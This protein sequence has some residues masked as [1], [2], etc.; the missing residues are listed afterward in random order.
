MTTK[1]EG[2]ETIGNQAPNVIDTF[3]IADFLPSVLAETM[4]ILNALYPNTSL[5]C[6]ANILL[7]KMGQVV[8]CKRIMFKELVNVKLINHYAINLM[9]SGLGKDRICDDIDKHFLKIFIIYF[10]D[11]ARDY[12]LNQENKINQDAIEKFKVEKDRKQYIKEEMAAIRAIEIEV[13]KA[14]PEG[15]FQDAKTLE[16]ADFGSIF[17][18]IAEFAQHLKSNNSENTDLT[19]MLFEAYDGKIPSKSI[20]YGRREKSIGNM[21][22]NALLHTD[23]TL[24]KSD[25]NGLFTNLMS[26]GLA[27][28]AFISFQQNNIT[29]IETDPKKAR[30]VQ[31]QAYKKAEQVSKNLFNIFLQIPDKAVYEITNRAYEDVFYP[32]K[33]QINDLGNQ[34]VED[35][36]LSKEI[37]SRELKVL[38]LAGM[39]ASLNHP[40]ELIINE[41]D[42]TQAIQTVE[43]L[44]KDF[45]KF[46]DYQPKINDGYENMFNFLLDNLGQK[47]PKT[48]LVKKHRD[49]GFSNRDNFRKDFDKILDNISE[50]AID[51]GY[52]LLNERFNNNSGQAISLVK[53]NIGGS[54][55]EDFRG[56]DEI[57]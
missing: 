18:K 46:K 35:E 51:K 5:N 57:T 56:L 22:V 21:P 50:I 44:S 11:K 12:L 7:A 52:I 36:L 40:T 23:Y 2:P 29:I 6:K 3:S 45:K 19:N 38:K 1:K 32:Y 53:S 17:I 27:R 42:I 10:N 14:T 8:S 24:L 16:K 54:L 39:F 34:F 25:L 48:P 4:S 55:P 43:Q 30:E 15:I 13:S 20:K 49:F 33:I 9:S 26:T 41:K 31:V 37:R 28:R 47:F